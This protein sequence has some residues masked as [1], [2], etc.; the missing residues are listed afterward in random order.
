MHDCKPVSTPIDSNHQ[1]KAIEDEDEHTDAT[2]YQQIIGSLMYL[3]TGTRPDLAYTIT[4]LSIQLIS[5]HK[6][7]TGRQES[8]SIS[9]RNEG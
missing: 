9:P 1:L 5:L 7:P 2:A 3:V 4:H 8:T 6:A